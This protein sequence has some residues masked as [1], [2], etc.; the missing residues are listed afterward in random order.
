MS[1]WNLGFLFFIFYSP[2]HTRESVGGQH[3]LKGLF[4]FLASFSKGSFGIC[5]IYILRHPSML[6]TYAFASHICLFCEAYTL[7]PS[8]S[9][10]PKNNRPPLSWIG[11]LRGHILVE[12]EAKEKTFERKKMR[13]KVSLM[14]C[15]IEQA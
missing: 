10:P 8:S 13:I 14:L 2:T 6:H 4:S 9:P 12:K 1:S 5:R 11:S 7:P 3:M 15:S